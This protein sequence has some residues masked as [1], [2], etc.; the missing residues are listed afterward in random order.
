MAGNNSII[1]LYSPALA[2]SDFQVFLHLKTFLGGRRFY[3]D[4]EIK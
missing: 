2:P 1:L 3:N 4:N